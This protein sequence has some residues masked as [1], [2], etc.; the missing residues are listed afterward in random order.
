MNQQINM[1]AFRNGDEEE[2]KKIVKMFNGPLKY[3]A[4]KLTGDILEAEDIAIESLTKALLRCQNFGTLSNLNAFLY[5]T[6][7]NACLNK[8]KQNKRRSWHEKKSALLQEKHVVKL[9][10]IEE[11]LLVELIKAI[12]F[13]PD[14]CREIFKLYYYEDMSI[15]EIMTALDKSRS[16]VTTQLH[17]GRQKLRELLDPTNN[18]S[19]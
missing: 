18:H 3:F 6:V 15:F 9:E 7:R 4:K 1:E 10:L 11:G 17:Y 16:N 2:G 8:L 12:E 19:R 14:S 5:I 13:L